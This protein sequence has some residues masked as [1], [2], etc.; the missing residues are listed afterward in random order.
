MHMPLCMK[1]CGSCTDASQSWHFC[2]LTLTGLQSVTAEL[3]MQVAFLLSAEPVV[4]A[5]WSAVL[6]RKFV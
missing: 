1:A 3:N 6:C 5:H 4:P 2:C